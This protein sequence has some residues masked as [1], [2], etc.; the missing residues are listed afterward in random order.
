MVKIIYLINPSQEVQQDIKECK[1][2]YTDVIN[3]D[4]I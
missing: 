2:G 3:I 4:I 1:E